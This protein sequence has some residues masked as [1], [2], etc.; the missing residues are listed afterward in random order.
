MYT[1]GVYVPVNAMLEVHPN[2]GLTSEE[3][4]TLLSRN[5]HECA[6]IIAFETYRSLSGLRCVS[7]M[8]QRP[9]IPV[10]DFDSF[11]ADCMS[12]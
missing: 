11:N 12:V 6:Y 9:G 7:V 4:M 8:V 2:A 5:E 1:T 3:Y 10:I